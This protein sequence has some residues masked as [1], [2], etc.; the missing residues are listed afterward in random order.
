MLRRFL[1]S[2]LTKSHATKSLSQNFSVHQDA[3]GME[4]IIEENFQKMIKD[5]DNKPE[6]L[7][8]YQKQL[9][10]RSRNLGM[11]EMDLLIGKWCRQNIHT[12]DLEETQ[13]LEREIFRVE[14][15]DLHRLMMME[16]EEIAE[17]ELP[18]D[19]FMFTIREFAKNPEW[20]IE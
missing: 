15:P 7:E 12:L 4:V 14:T 8:D 9:L 19:H 13:R 18:D 6:S 2:N 3:P 1:K 5:Y 17:Y 20:N 16:P 10:W 11:L